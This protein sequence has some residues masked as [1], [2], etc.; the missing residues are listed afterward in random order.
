M[1]GEAVGIVSLGMNMEY[2]WCFWKVETFGERMLQIEI[3]RISRAHLLHCKNCTFVR[4]MFI[5]YKLIYKKK[6][7]LIKQIGNSKDNL[8]LIFGFKPKFY[9]AILAS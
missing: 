4:N 6:K 2:L 1:T 7:T 8:A 3:F 9:V 5:S